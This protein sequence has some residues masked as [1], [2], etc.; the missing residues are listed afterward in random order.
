MDLK[1]YF[2]IQHIMAITIFIICSGTI[3][4][5]LTHNELDNIWNIANFTGTLVFLLC[6][7]IVILNPNPDKYFTAGIIGIGFGVMMMGKFLYFFI[8][9]TYISFLLGLVGVGVGFLCICCALPLYCGN[10]FDTKRLQLFILIYI[11]GILVA[12]LISTLIGN[13]FLEIIV[14]Y[15]EEFLLII[16]LLM[17][18]IMLN[19][20][21]I[22]YASLGKRIKT[23]FG[24]FYDSLYYDNAT[25]MTR[26][27]YLATDDDDWE[28]VNEGPIKEQRKIRIIS[29]NRKAYIYFYKW[30]DGSIKGEIC[31]SDKGTLVQTT[32]FDVTAVVPNGDEDTCDSFTIYGKEGFFITI[33]V[34]DKIDKR[35]MSLPKRM[36]CSI[37]GYR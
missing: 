33:L 8:V 13:N 6:S 9:D 11:A 24:M 29:S 19:G 16:P 27:D 28:T 37:L 14:E 18:M 25:Y 1:R 32:R 15:Q 12:C 20:K 10:R 23:S 31:R 2:N 30:T 36:L 5:I 22:G 17:F 4:Y 35:D 21:G 3:T 26:T 7:V 34:L